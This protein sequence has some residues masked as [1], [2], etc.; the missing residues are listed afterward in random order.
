MQDSLLLMMTAEP[1]L[2]RRL[3]VIV[4]LKP[5]LLYHRS[6]L[7]TCICNLWSRFTRRDACHVML[8]QSSRNVTTILIL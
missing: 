8:Y 2:S 7:D 3:S 4:S 1:T 6:K 5:W